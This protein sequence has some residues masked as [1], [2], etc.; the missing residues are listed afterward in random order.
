[1]SPVFE[2]VN[3]GNQ[4]ECLE[5]VVGV[6]VDHVDEGLAD[7]GLHLASDGVVEESAYEGFL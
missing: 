7:G 2:V 6:F 5:F 4:V 1:M 3:L